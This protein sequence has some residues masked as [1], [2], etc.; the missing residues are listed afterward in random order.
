[1]DTSTLA[2]TLP[3]RWARLL[4]AEPEPTWLAETQRIAREADARRQF[5]D[6]DTGSITAFEAYLLRALCE[7]FQSRVVIEVG[8]FIGTST[9]AM[10]AASTVD[11]IYTCDISNECLGDDEVVH[12][13]PK[14]SSVEM[15]RELVNR[16]VRSDFCFFDGVLRDEDV[17]L[18]AK[19]TTPDVVFATHDYNYGPKKRVRHGQ[20]YY[21]TVPRK[22]IGN[23][24]LLKQRW[25]HHILIDPLPETTVALLVPESRL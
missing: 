23:I 20:S 18:L 10:F 22:G 14:Q 19:V 24:D 5:A 17:D 1:M 2:V 3:K 4:P 9:D 21:E 13:F 7:H 15:L 12:T 16:G 8:T 6:Y 11:D 25:R